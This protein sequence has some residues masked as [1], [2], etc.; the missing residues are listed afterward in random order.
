MSDVDARFDL[1]VLNERGEGVPH[2]LSDAYKW[3][4]IAAAPTTYLR[5]PHRG[6]S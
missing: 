3:H 5:S 2:S 6:R 1:A 4:A